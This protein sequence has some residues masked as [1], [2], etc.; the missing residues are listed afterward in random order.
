[1]SL[2]VSSSLNTIEIL[3]KQLASLFGEEEEKKK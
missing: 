2:P 1:M 3:K